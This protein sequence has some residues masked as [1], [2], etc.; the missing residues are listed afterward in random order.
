MVALLFGGGASEPPAPAT[1]RATASRTRRPINGNTRTS[2]NADDDGGFFDERAAAYYAAGALTLAEGSGG[3]GAGGG[4][5]GTPVA[6]RLSAAP[7]PTSVARRHSVTIT[8][9]V[10]PSL[11]ARG[12]IRVDVYGPTGALTLHRTYAARNFKAGSTVTV[13]P[14]FLISS[15]RRL[16]RYTVRIRILSA[17]DGH[18]LVTKTSS[19][20]FRVHA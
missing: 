12:R 18:T 5:G 8:T 7:S 2:L 6:W 17:I 1:R 10:R 14:S 16:G 19:R 13:R 3:G 20:T 9:R 4:G 11:S 15:S